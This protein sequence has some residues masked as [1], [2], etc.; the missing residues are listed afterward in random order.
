MVKY[1]KIKKKKMKI[2]QQLF[3]NVATLKFYKGNGNSV[4]L[5]DNQNYVNLVEQL[6]KDQTK[7]KILE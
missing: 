2:K 7:F 4:V 3:Q 1:L 6:F 5:L